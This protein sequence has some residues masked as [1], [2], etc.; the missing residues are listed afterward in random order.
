MG[1]GDCV[2]VARLGQIGQVMALDANGA[3][4]QVGNFRVRLKLD[5][6]G[7]KVAEPEAPRE[8]IA[9]SVSLPKAESPG[10]EVSLRG[11]RADDA[12]D[13]LEKYLNRAYLAGLPYVRVV[14]GKGT[15]TLRKLTRDFLRGHPLV[16]QIR[17]AEQH[18]G[19][20]GVTIV[21][22]VAR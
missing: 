22:L 3:D 13:R 6:L 1:V 9:S 21:K 7:E 20:E 17:E 19:G 16:A 5:E 14:H 10:I 11:L 8:K 12:L 18:E 4:V 15:G 2:W